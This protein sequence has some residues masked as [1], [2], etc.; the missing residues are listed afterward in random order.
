MIANTKYILPSDDREEIVSKINYNFYQLYFNSVGGEGP[1]GPKGPT[2]LIGQAG[3]PGNLGPTGQKAT[4]WYFQTFPP[5]GSSIGDFWVDVGLT[6]GRLI[7]EFNGVSWVNTGEN[8][9]SDS[10][11]SVVNS[12]Q[13]P[14]S[15]VDHN[16]VVISYSTPQTPGNYS[17]VLSDSVGGTATVNPTLS[18][19]LLS[20]DASQFVNPLLS[21][22][23]D[24]MSSG[25]I[26]SYV[27]GNVGGNYNLEFNTPNNL[28][29]SSGG[30]SEYTATGGS[31]FLV[32]QLTSTIT[33]STTSFVGATGTSGAFSINSSSSL[34]FSSN[35]TEITPSSFSLFGFSAIS[36]TTHSS[37]NSINLQA[38]NGVRS[39]IN[40]TSESQNILGVTNVA[41]L[42]GE[43]YFSSRGGGNNVIGNRG[44]T[45]SAGVRVNLVKPFTLLNSNIE[46]TFSNPPFTNSYIEVPI[47]NLYE[48][49]V[50]IIIGKVGLSPISADGKPNRFYLQFSTFNQLLTG[51]GEVRTFDFL[52]DNLTYSFGGIR[53]VAPAVNT[54]IPISD[55]GTGKNEGC[56]HIRITFMPSL[57]RF[58]YN[59]YS[60]SNNLCGFASYVATN[61]EVLFVPL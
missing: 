19:V 4:N 32:S 61:E 28:T 41:G 40:S 60:T 21:F 45:G 15:A 13:G 39:N 59:A 23:K 24:F 38:L 43:Y 18:K 55:T 6:G 25:E 54:I 56:R 50:R 20:T 27:W 49:V 42:T 1:I 10:V 3:N 14:G 9:L 31:L 44:L 8:L 52:L 7:Y 35:R 36:S 5:T 51:L 34:N 11:F 16:A 46:T 57:N 47:S 48:D 53:I 58:Y 30:N 22:G 33:A 2:G 12:I 37:S 26:P 17:V 29:Y